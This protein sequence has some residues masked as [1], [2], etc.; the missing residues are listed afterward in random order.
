[1]TSVYEVDVLGSE[2]I[3]MDRKRLEADARSTIKAMVVLTSESNSFLSSNNGL[4][5][6]MWA[7]GN[8][9]AIKKTPNCHSTR[10][11]THTHIHTHTHGS[12]DDARDLDRWLV[13]TS[14]RVQG[15]NE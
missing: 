11:H 9:H 10:V 6:W 15:C 7:G 1:M 8:A 2:K 3:V 5:C 4:R 13:D 12:F 14:K